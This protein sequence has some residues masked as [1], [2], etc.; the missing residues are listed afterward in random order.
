MS[1]K[2]QCLECPFAAEF[3]CKSRQ[4]L[5]ALVCWLEDRKI[6]ELEI[7]E[8]EELR[9]DSE[10]WDESVL[11]YLERLS[12]PFRWPNEDTDC[13][14]WL[15][16]FAV[17]I[18]YD[19]NVATNFINESV[20]HDHQSPALNNT[21][22]TPAG[23]ISNEDDIALKID[24]IG[25]LLKLE[26][27]VGESNHGMIEHDVSRLIAPLHNFCYF[28]FQLLSICYHRYASKSLRIY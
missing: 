13:I 24:E 5:I 16:A 8:R 26:R 11:R 19:E 9:C 25:N 17:S 10:I 2:L 3:D 1:Q 18:E 6:R 4:H 12:C 28:S 23:S 15:I 7:S 22:G 27:L 14:D 20:H 21:V